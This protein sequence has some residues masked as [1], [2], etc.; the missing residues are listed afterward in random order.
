MYGKKGKLSHRYGTKHSE[1][2][3]NKIKE[4]LKNK[5]YKKICKNCNREFDTKYART[6]YCSADCKRKYRDNHNK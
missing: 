4:S 6:T 1:E 5:V 2:T 3:K